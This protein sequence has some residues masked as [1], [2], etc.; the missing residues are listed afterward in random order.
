M[1]L[2]VLVRTRPL[3][4]LGS[5]GQRVRSQIH[6]FRQKAPG[7]ICVVRLYLFVFCTSQQ[8]FCLAWATTAQIALLW[9]TIMPRHSFFDFVCAKLKKVMLCILKYAGGTNITVMET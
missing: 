4:I 6:I 9:E 5:L 8:S 2:L 1:F 3:L 7:G